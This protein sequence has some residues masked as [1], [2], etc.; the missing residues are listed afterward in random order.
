MSDRTASAKPV[1]NDSIRDHVSYFPEETV[2]V[3]RSCH[4]K[5]HTDE[6]FHPELTPTQDERDRVY[7]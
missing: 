3:C 5:L 6:S 2:T 4:N 7:G 1:R